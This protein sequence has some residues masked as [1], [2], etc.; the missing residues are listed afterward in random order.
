MSGIQDSRKTETYQGDANLAGLLKEQR[1]FTDIDGL[2]AMIAGVAAAPAGDRA[3]DWINLVAPEASEAV[4]AQLLAFRAG[5]KPGGTPSPQTTAERVA[6]AINESTD[7]LRV[8]VGNVLDPGYNR[9]HT[10]LQTLERAGVEHE[11]DGVD[12]DCL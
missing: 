12:P 4:R 10:L 11:F 6:T 3:D 8:Y 9:T 7:L 2:K 1:S 5:F